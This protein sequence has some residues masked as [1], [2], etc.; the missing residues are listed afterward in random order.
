MTRTRRNDKRSGSLSLVMGEGVGSTTPD[1]RRRPP[2]LETRISLN[3]V[4][5]QHQTKNC[6]KSPSREAAAECR[7]G[8]D[9]TWD[10]EKAKP[11]GFSI[12]KIVS[13]MKSPVVDSCFTR[14]RWNVRPGMIWGHHASFGLALSAQIGGADDVFVDRRGCLRVDRPVG[15]RGDVLLV[16]AGLPRGVADDRRHGRLD[17]HRPPHPSAR[18]RRGALGRSQG[19]GEDAA[20]GRR[21]H[22]TGE[23]QGARAEGGGCRRDD[24]RADQRRHGVPCRV[25]PRRRREGVERRLR[26]RARGVGGGE[27]DAF[28]FG[29]HPV[30][31]VV[32]HAADDVRK[33]VRGGRGGFRPDPR[34]G[35]ERS[36]DRPFGGRDRGRPSVSLDHPADQSAAGRDGA[37]A[38]GRRRGDDPRHRPRRRHPGSGGGGVPGRNREERRSPRVGTSPTKNSPRSP[39]GETGGRYRMGRINRPCRSAANPHGPSA[40]R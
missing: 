30:A 22:H 6:S 18:L 35:A 5:R 31:R 9:V 27:H 17:R 40:T 25:L 15:H 2:S 16:R 33:A 3:G 26:G 10:L 38:L 34:F 20:G 19:G 8:L 12:P 14:R 13:L 36:G 11:E 23:R 1:R 7:G 32:G 37:A 24:G 28:P 29:R 4:G 21:L 39:V